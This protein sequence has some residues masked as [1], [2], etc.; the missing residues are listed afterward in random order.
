MYQ[1]GPDFAIISETWERKRQNLDAL[2]NSE[3]YKTIS[4][5][6]PKV[7]S[8]RQPAGG[9]AIV[10]NDSR[11]KVTKEVVDTPEK[12]ETVWALCEPITQSA[13]I[14]VKRIII[15]SVYVAP[16]SQHKL[17]TIDHIIG[18]IHSFRAKYDNNV[19]FLIG[20]DVNR[21]NIT[22]I[23]DS[24]GGL[25]QVCS[26]PTRK[27]ATLE[28][29]LTDLH[30]LYHPPTTLPPLQVDERKDGKDSDHNIVVF[31]P[32]I[33]QTFEVRR[34]KKVIKT[35]PLPRSNFGPFELEMQAQK[36][37]EVLEAKDANLKVNNFHRIIRR[38]LENNFPEKTV[39]ISN[40]DKKWFTPELK[41]IHRKMQR[42]YYKKRRSPK[43]L[44][45]KK[46]FKALKRKS[47]KS[48]YSGFVNELKSTNPGKWYQMAKR[49]GALDVMNDGEV[50]V[51]ILDGLS[52]QDGA[53]MIAQHFASIA[54]EYSPLDT[55]QLPAYLP[56][57]PPPQVTEYSVY[58]RLENLKKTKSTLSLD[59]PNEI[60]KAF[61][62]EL[63]TPVT[64]II[65]IV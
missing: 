45:L 5:A 38:M 2:L 56:S 26:V 14:K 35:R 27:S 22:N 39:K 13:N 20:G 61:S 28:V 50:K 16:N 49:I 44:K 4:Y 31:A 1:I 55:S 48:F 15:G 63:A 12:V 21:L 52:N 51:E 58:K 11:F 30:S 24:Y 23:L 64:D 19:N 43:W 37:S 6:R 18:A 42:E 62:L 59:L 46:S 9:C 41:Q 40:L 7:V 57:L 36:W 34:K 32:L 33:N 54:N 10:Y 17:K 29:V 25:K 3:H 8:N 60:R 47:I 53:E 65:N